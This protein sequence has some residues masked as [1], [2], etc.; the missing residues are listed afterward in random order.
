[1]RSI[2]STWRRFK[3][4]G[5][6]SKVKPEFSQAAV[7]LFASVCLGLGIFGGVVESVGGRILVFGFGAWLFWMASREGKET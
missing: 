7:F 5:A 2:R 1:M 4:G 6:I 3:G